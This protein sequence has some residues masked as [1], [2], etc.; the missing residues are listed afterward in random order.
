MSLTAVST[1]ACREQPAVLPAAIPRL[2]VVTR[3]VD[4]RYRSPDVPSPEAPTAEVGGERRAV[5]SHVVPLW[6]HSGG[7]TI[8]ADRSLSIDV[9]VP[10]ELRG[11]P[12][13]L[14]ATAEG[15]GVSIADQTPWVAAAASANVPVHLRMGGEGERA[16]LIITG[17]NPAETVYETGPVDVPPDA[18]LRF[19]TGVD[20]SEWPPDL[21]AAAFRLTAI[22]GGKETV[23]FQSRMDPGHEPKERR[24]ADHEIDLGAFAGRSVRFRFESHA[25]PDDPSRPLIYPVWSD[26]TLLV[27]DRSASR[28][29]NLIIISLD[30][31]RA[32]RLGCY[33]YQRP[34]SPAIDRLLAARGTLF[35]NA[36][37]Q[38]PSTAGSHMTIFTSLYSCVH[39]VKGDDL[40]GKEYLRP[41]V[42]TLA[43]VLRAHGDETAAFTDDGWLTAGLG[44]ARGFGTFVESRG[45]NVW[46]PE[47][48][49][50]KTFPA[51]L[52]WIQRHPE[53]PWF[54]FMHTYQVHNPYTP[55]P[56]DLEAVAPGSG[57]ETA[58]A[59]SDLYDGE[60]R[61]TD[62]LLG[63]FLAALDA[64]PEG[65]PTIVV[66]L[67]DHGEQFGEHGLR[68]HGNS[69][70][71]VLLHVPL[72]I[73]APGL[74]AS[75]ARI[76][77]PVGLID[78]MPTV[79]EMLEIAPP[80]MI[81]GRSLVPLLHGGSLAPTTL[82]A[83]LPQRK[84]LAA[85][86]AQ[87]K[88]IIDTSARSAQVYDLRA[89]PGETLDLG[90]DVSSESGGRL[91]DGFRLLC[92][93]TPGRAPVA[94]PA[95]L[96][97]AVR[98]KLKALGYAD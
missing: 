93:A 88:W 89:D 68:Y 36:F 18:R 69:L 44:F 13:R 54:V 26:P 63:E 17:R 72:M 65:D 23:L 28:P 38:F 52:A 48:Q 31:L 60:I 51:A 55:P 90:H 86:T 94:G 83:E 10:D 46:K 78:V 79:L 4:E 20:E 2:R 19:G 73:R 45:V 29:R 40:T 47:G 81:Q 57:K 8:P 39:Q 50:D 70:Y 7:A 92:S 95:P 56:A 35:T 82:Y 97:P 9:A 64:T 5:I 24:W 21:P 1:S 41:D 71:D 85:K 32:D 91:L 16:F 80:A 75:G 77:Q 76:D 96:D 66:L 22:E 53:V 15:R 67:S 43:D 87:R 84:Q 37:S 42:Q 49:A 6:L 59:D 61:Y 33:G 98:E 34:T 74:V 58:A 3:L 30:T 12:L 27:A 25:E 11:A 14:S 62:R